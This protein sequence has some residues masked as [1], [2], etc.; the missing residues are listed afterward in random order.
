[1]RDFT[2][3]K[4]FGGTCVGLTALVTSYVAG[5]TDWILIALPLLGVLAYY[6]FFGDARNG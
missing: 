5:A 6:A 1:M 2:E 4:P 3:T